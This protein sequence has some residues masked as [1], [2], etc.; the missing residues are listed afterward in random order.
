[1]SVEMLLSILVGKIGCRLNRAR[2]KESSGLPRHY[3]S[4]YLVIPIILGCF[5]YMVSIPTHLIIMVNF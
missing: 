4:T 2:T 1:M 3:L 5:M